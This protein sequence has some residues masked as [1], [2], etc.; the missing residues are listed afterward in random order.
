[1]PHV[2]CVEDNAETALLLQHILRKAAIQVTSTNNGEAALHLARQKQYDL[3]LL[4]VNMPVMNGFELCRLFKRDAVLKEIPV[5][6]LTVS[7]DP[8][9]QTEA[10]AAGASNF[11]LK[12]ND[13]FEL[14]NCIKSELALHAMKKDGQKKKL[15]QDAPMPDSPEK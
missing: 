14:P 10:Y 6:I 13:L 11:F 3:I 9:Y 15:A 5:I 4:D 2:L 12:T 7:N 8:Q 1:M